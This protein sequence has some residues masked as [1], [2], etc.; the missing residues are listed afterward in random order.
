MGILKI[1]NSLYQNKVNSFVICFIIWN[2]FVLENCSSQ[3]YDK[4]WILGD[5]PG[6]QMTF[7]DTG[8]QVKKILTYGGLDQT[9]SSISN[10]TNGRL[11]MYT[12]GCK[13]FDSDYNIMEGGD[14]ISPG[15][16]ELLYCKDFGSSIY[17]QGAIIL[18]LIPEREIYGVFNLNMEYYLQGE[19]Y[20][21][22]P[23]K[24]YM[25]KV[26]MSLNNNKGKVILK[27]FAILNDTLSNSCVNAVRHAN[28]R[29]WWLTVPENISNCYYVIRIVKDSIYDAVKQCLG[30][31]IGK[32]DI[33]GQ[34]CFSPDGQWY[35]RV[36]S[37]YGLFLYHFD[38]SLGT[39]SA[40]IHFQNSYDSTYA[41]GVSISPNS[42]YLYVNLLRKI[43]QYDL[44]APDIKASETQVAYWD[45]TL[46]PTASSF[47]H[48]ALAPDGKIYI[49]TFTT[50]YNLGIILKPDCP[51]LASMVVQHAVRL[52]VYNQGSIPNLPHYNKY[53]STYSCVNVTM[54]ESLK[55]IELNPNPANSILRI[56]QN[57]QFRIKCIKITDLYGNSFDLQIEDKSINI[58]RLVPGIYFI[59]FYFEDNE[60]TIL[61][62]V[63]I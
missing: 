63:K 39:F 31:T 20:D 62:F 9:N 7:V 32:Y 40:P 15:Y 24:L 38:N 56:N 48:S 61:K 10:P 37:E 41:A 22:R 19:H 11:L 47:Y 3:S 51:G 34:A 57:E 53:I 17:S 55:K 45:G 14:T 35:A 54:K 30:D 49:G 8:V 58:E 50:N 13:I 5:R 16:L 46:D 21:I 1:I 27:N 36:Y 26:D 52:P 33:Q 12:N 6:I 59:Q 4:N 60:P 18:P 43:L 23:H 42:K 25:Q 44:S 28:G 29:D 2:G